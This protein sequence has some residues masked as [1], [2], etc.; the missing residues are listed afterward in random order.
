M[1]FAY[2]SWRGGSTRGTLCLEGVW[3]WKS[4]K[5]ECNRLYDRTSEAKS[6]NARSIAKKS[7]MLGMGRLVNMLCQRAMCSRGFMV[8]SR[9]L[10]ND[11]KGQLVICPAMLASI[12][13]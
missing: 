1:P 6:R 9:V 10:S 5:G 7:A 13:A 8:Q 12:P 3:Y 2:A 4:L 11:M